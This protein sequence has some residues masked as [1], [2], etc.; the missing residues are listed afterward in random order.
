MG[1]SNE[2]AKKEIRNYI[3]ATYN[4]IKVKSGKCRYNFYCHANA[5]HEASKHKHKKIAMCFYIDEG[6]P[7][8]HFINYHNGKFVDN[9]LGEWSQLHTYYFVKWIDE[10][11]FYNVFNIFKAFRQEVRKKLSWWV[12]L[13]SDY[14]C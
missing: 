14:E 6:C 8:V 4:T 12:K 13:T 10:D 2:R 7:I 1:M 5:V 9:T 3:L 11:D